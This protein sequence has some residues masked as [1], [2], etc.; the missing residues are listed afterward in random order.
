[1]GFWGWVWWG[2]SGSQ[3]AKTSFSFQIS[4]NTSAAPHQLSGPLRETLSRVR[5]DPST[6][7]ADADARL[8]SVL[9]LLLNEYGIFDL[10]SLAAC[11][12]GVQG[13]MLAA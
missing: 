9:R 13:D 8:A 11:V 5:V 10:D 4:P 12:G 2:R 3:S 1:M 7:M 6:Y